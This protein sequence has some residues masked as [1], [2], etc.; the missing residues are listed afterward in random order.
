M[1]RIRKCKRELTPALFNCIVVAVAV[2]KFSRLE[3]CLNCAGGVQPNGNCLRSP[4]T[5]SISFSLFRFCQRSAR[6]GTPTTHL[7][8]QHPAGRRN[9]ARRGHG[10]PC[11]LVEGFFG[12]P[13]FACFKHSHGEPG[14]AKTG[15]QLL[16]SIYRWLLESSTVLKNKPTVAIFAPAKLLGSTWSDGCYLFF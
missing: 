16:P 14:N 10:S 5:F 1:H 7:H 13:A 3:R 12:D 8:R 6:V 11:A 4:Q 9:S 2:A 15:S